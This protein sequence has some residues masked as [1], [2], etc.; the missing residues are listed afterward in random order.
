[1]NH[2]VTVPPFFPG[3]WIWGIVLFQ[4]NLT[5]PYQWY[6]VILLGLFHQHIGTPCKHKHM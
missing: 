4:G 6:L 3:I 1:M 2:S 5:E